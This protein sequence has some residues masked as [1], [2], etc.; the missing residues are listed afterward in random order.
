MS[1]KDI[2]YLEYLAEK[3][4]KGNLSE[5]ERNLLR[6]FFNDEYQRAE[7][8][9]AQMGSKEHVSGQLY[10]K[11]KRRA[12]FGK[13]WSSYTKYAIAAMITIVIG[14]GLLLKPQAPVKQLTIATKSTIDSVKLTDGSTVYLAANSTFKYPEHFGAEIRS[15]TLLKGNAF[16]KVAKDPAHPFIISSGAV[17]TK[18]L[19]TS[20]HIG[21]DKN[22]TSVSV[23]TGHV[24]VS[25]KQSVAFLEP[26]ESAVFTKEAGLQK[27][28]TSNAFLYNWFE[29][30]INLN[31]VN[32]NK[33]LTILNFNY[34]V[35][36]KADDPK[37]LDTR[38]TLYLN[39]GLPLQDILNQLKYIT[40]LKFT[41]NGENKIK[42]S[43]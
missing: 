36:F 10:A 2:H 8:D 14:A 21:L 15:V 5:A 27:E 41:A 7:W 23:V 34:G 9:V 28:Q 32:L 19:G 31:N 40:H 12:G 43:K 35:C 22:K 17:T 6:D 4:E 11:I 33:V 24:K 18:V 38:I 29:K 26:N 20:F 25:A 37:I 13:S 42:V 3:E 1:K 16:F 39:T 30:D